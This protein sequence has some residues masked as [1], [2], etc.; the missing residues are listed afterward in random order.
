MNIS[1]TTALIEKQ[2]RK[3]SL[4]ND[5]AID[6]EYVKSIFPQ[7]MHGKSES[8]EEFKSACSLLHTICSRLEDGLKELKEIVPQD[9]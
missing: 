5:L 2:K 4:I 6:F 8:D 1:E 9:K 7:V 3:A